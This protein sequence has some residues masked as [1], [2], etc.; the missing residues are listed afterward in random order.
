MDIITILMD[1][2]LGDDGY[3]EL[4]RLNLRDRVDFFVT[5]QVPAWRVVDSLLS[6]DVRIGASQVAFASLDRVLSLTEI[7]QGLKSVIY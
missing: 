5:S 4:V 3:A 7:H 2:A 1:V 6:Q